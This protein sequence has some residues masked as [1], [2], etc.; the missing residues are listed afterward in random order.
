MRQPSIS[1]ETV[2]V[3]LGCRVLRPLAASALL[4]M[5]AA[6]LPATAAGQAPGDVPQPPP[7]YAITNARIVTGAGPV[8]EEGTVVIANGL[9]AAVGAGVAVPPE[10]WVIDG[11]G[12]TVYPGL[13]D[14][15]TD[16]GLPEDGAQAGAQARA[17]APSGGSQSD[18]PEDRPA[19]FPARAAA[20]ALATDDARIET[21][22]E[23]GYTTVMTIP[24]DGFVTGQGAVI[25]LGEVEAREMV[26]RAPVALRLNLRASRGNRGYPGSLFGVLAYLN[27]LFLDADRQTRALAADQAR[28][29]GLE[30][31]AY[32]PT[33][34]PL[35]RAVS[36][37]W[38][39][40]IPGDEPREILRALQLGDAL[41]VRTVVYGAQGGYEV[42]AQLAAARAPV[43]VNL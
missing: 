24:N 31:P 12:L 22:R 17:A 19:T 13:F 38:P 32:D 11:E 16:L 7:Y 4:A 26:V 3:I 10:A 39:V 5:L 28:P 41:G 14:A 27:Q 23:G 40:L 8:I 18:G 20:E 34:E 35:G 37:R 2:R 9:I 30:R 29:A 36:E 42:A 21:W 15:L 33:L 1:A 43:L 6:A 25:A